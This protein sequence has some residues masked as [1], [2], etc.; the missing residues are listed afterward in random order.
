MF[1]VHLY[2]S[3]IWRLPHGWHGRGKQR[4]LVRHAFLSV[5]VAHQYTPNER[6]HVPNKNDT[7]GTH[8]R[9]LPARPP[10]LD[11]L[12]NSSNYQALTDRQIRS[13]H[14]CRG[15]PRQTDRKARV[16][17]ENVMRKWKNKTSSGFFRPRI[18]GRLGESLHLK[19]KNR[20]DSLSQ[21]SYWGS[22]QCWGVLK[23]NNSS[24]MTLSFG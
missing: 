24:C 19:K 12:L 9:T 16:T 2:D 23:G 22:W 10:G 4:Y 7:H 8:G 1:P 5:R 21:P 15:L 14:G 18:K 6:A 17:V 3:Q 20:I 13:E 11:D